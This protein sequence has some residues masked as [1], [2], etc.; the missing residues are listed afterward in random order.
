MVGAFG[1]VQIMDW[2]L[3]KDLTDHTDRLDEKSAQA[4]DEQ[5]PRSST[6]KNADT[7]VT[8]I[9]SEATLVGSVFGTIAYMSPEQAN[10]QTVII[11]K[12]SDVFSLGAVLCRLLTGIPPYQDSEKSVDQETM[13][14]RAQARRS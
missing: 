13:L 8:P 11:D 9:Q 7:L 5:Q 4:G 6:D 1:E 14:L 12:W 3:A 2:G 10:G